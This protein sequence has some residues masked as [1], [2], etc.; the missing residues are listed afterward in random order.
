M[1]DNVNVSGKKWV[2]DD[3]VAACFDDMLKRSIPDYENMRRVVYAIGRHYAKLGNTI[4]DI[5]CSN[6]AAALP[7]VQNFKNEF[8]LLDVSNSMLDLAR[9]GFKGYPNVDVRYHDLRNGMPKC[10]A[11]LV[12]SILTLQFTPIE[13]RHAI[14]KSV[15]DTLEPGGALV[16]VEKLLGSTADVDSVLTQ[17]YYDLKREHRYTQEQISDKRRALEGVLVPVTEAWNIEILKSA[18]FSKI[19]SFWR[20][21]NFAGYLAV[22]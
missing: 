15:Y 11:S 4:V 19:D 21:L 20:Y 3:E 16:L 5:G 10:R 9:R 8:I 14:V 6:G 7:F 2:F 18:G 12:L 13:Y 1:R 22:K 17:E